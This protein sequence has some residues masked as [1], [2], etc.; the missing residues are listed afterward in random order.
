MKNTKEQN[1][2]ERK[3]IRKQKDESNI[4][5]KNDNSKINEEIIQNTV[6]Q[7]RSFLG[8]KTKRQNSNNSLKNNLYPKK[9]F[10]FRDLIEDNISDFIVFNSINDILTLIYCNKNNSIISYDLITNKKIIEVK[11]ENCFMW[12]QSN[13][14]F[15]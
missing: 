13:K 11:R 5:D 8:L 2:N 1:K 9:L 14:I 10:D 15:L 4:K 12:F 7:E 3:N 6:N